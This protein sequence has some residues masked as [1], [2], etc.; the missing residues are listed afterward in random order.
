MSR[1]PYVISIVYFFIFLALSSSYASKNTLGILGSGLF[2][3]RS[4]SGGDT[5]GIP[6]QKQYA[7]LCKH[8][9]HLVSFPLGKGHFASRVNYHSNSDCSFHLI[10]LIV[11]GDITVNPRLEKCVVCLQ[12]VA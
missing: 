3:T 7:C 5:V 12:T 4:N 2:H 11:S 8:V 1:V 9:R 6:P 10:R